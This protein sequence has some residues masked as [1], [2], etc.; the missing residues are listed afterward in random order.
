MQII[1]PYNFQFSTNF[2]ANDHSNKVKALKLLNDTVLASGSDDNSVKIWE[3][4]TATCLKTINTG[5]P[6]NSLLLLPD[7]LLAVAMDNSNIDVYN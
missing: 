4:A 7:D 3:Y 6:V 1:D 2:L 5:S